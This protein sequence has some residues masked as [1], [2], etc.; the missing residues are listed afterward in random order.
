MA[1]ELVTGYSGTAHVSSSEDGARQAGTVG[2]GMYVLE[3][4]EEPLAATL[5]NANT[6][7]VGPGDVLINGRHVQLTGS[8]TFA[9][10]VGT[11]GQQTSNLLVL[12]YDVAEDGTESVTPQTLTGQPSSASPADPALAT[13]DILAGD[14]PVDMPLYRVVTTG[15]ETAQPVRLFSTIPPIAS[16]PGVGAIAEDD[17]DATDSTKFVVAPGA[18]GALATKTGARVWSWLVGKIRSAFGFGSDNLLPASRV[19]GT[20][21]VAHGGTGATAAAQARTNLGCPP[22]SHAS[23]AT[24]YGA[25]T[26]TA[27]GHL[28]LSDSSTSTSNV[29]GGYAA[30]PA[31]VKA[32][33]DLLTQWLGT[34]AEGNGSVK[35]PNGL[36]INWGTYPAASMAMVASG[37][38]KADITYK[39]AFASYCVPF[40]SARYSS[41]F[42]RVAVSSYTKTK[43]SVLCDVNISGCYIHWLAVGR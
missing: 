7:T 2:T 10:P 41:G 40:V 28:R 20:L 27:Y 32:V 19:S 34:S 1:V 33:R 4:V 23:T 5:E 31:A 43:V 21:P 16:L 42:P 39:T 38:Y 3:T 15:I 8:T 37:V 24:T 18:G 13:G 25:G 12:R 11:Q 26:G 29:S 30:S 36:V 35:L 6:V 22:T 17:S 9:I 14:A